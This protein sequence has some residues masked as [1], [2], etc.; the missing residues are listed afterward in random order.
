MPI[1]LLHEV[2]ERNGKGS[3]NCFYRKSTI[4]RQYRAIEEN[5]G[6]YCLQKRIENFPLVS[7]HFH[8]IGLNFLTILLVDFV[9]V[10]SI[11]AAL[12]LLWTLW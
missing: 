6:L 10:S 2:K 11:I 7:V 1:L 3:G 9:A 8:E 12:M 4:R 5:N